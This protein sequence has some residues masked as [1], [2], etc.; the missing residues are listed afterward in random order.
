MTIRFIWDSPLGFLTQLT[1]DFTR[2]YADFYC[3]GMSESNE[4]KICVHL[5]QICANLRQD[6]GNRTLSGARF[7][8]Q[9]ANE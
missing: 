2:I 8:F 1:A 6:I 7:V 5:R 4:K 3:S 9:E